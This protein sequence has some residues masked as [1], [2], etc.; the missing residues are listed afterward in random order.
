[1]IRYKVYNEQ[2]PRAGLNIDQWRLQQVHFEFKSES[3]EY[4]KTPHRDFQIRLCLTIVFTKAKLF[5][6]CSYACVFYQLVY[7]T[8]IKLLCGRTNTL[9]FA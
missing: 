2:H 4:N 7:I 5:F 3:T 9:I 8:L 1:M 6:S